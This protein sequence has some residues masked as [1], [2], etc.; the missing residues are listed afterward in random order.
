VWQTTIWG[1]G[2]SVVI[3]L[4]AGI[5]MSG[6]LVGRVRGVLD[7]LEITGA[8]NDLTLRAVESG[9][10]EITMLAKGTNGLLCTLHS[11]ISEVSSATTQV[12]AAATE[13]AA[14]A[15][16]MACAVGE[17]ARQTTSAAQRSEDSGKLAGEGGAIV[18]ATV[19]GMKEI[20]TAVSESA[21]SVSALG[22]RGEEIG[23]IISV[24]NDIAD[25]TNLLALNAA[26]E[27]ARAGEHGRGFA[28]VADEVRKLADRTTKATEEIGGS[29]KAIQ[30]ETTTAASR[31][32]RGNEQ[33]RSGVANAEKAGASLE[34][35][36]AGTR[37]LASMIM[38]ISAASEEA[39]AG[40]SESASAATEL[41]TKAE[42]LRALVER[43]KV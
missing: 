8:T 3:C 23:Q 19:S 6:R 7:V 15:E 16:E 14:S 32:N 33:V 36:V 38:S 42:Q 30:G 17:V 5:V 4:A 40:A 26:I 37:D 11:I 27:A 35:I 28:V 13:I 12:A 1:L 41:S 25:Q 9:N 2:V 34:Q 39:G 10:D 29:I 21:S 18:Q 31:M 24:I 43:F 20:E 22:K